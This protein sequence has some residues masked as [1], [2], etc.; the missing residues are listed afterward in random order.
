MHDEFYIGMESV[1]PKGEGGGCGDLGV[2]CSDKFLLFGISSG[3]TK[4]LK[5]KN[6][7]CRYLLT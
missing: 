4:S 7:L 3:L 1:R 6:L 2:I 5:V